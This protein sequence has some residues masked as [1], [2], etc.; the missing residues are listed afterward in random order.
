MVMYVLVAAM[1]LLVVA[2]AAY[3]IGRS[4]QMPSAPTAQSP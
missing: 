1:A 2:G 3:F 4:A